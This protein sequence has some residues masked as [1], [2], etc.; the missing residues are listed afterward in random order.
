[1]LSCGVL[2]SCAA[3][4]ALPDRELDTEPAESGAD[5]PS[6][7]PPG[8]DDAGGDGGADAATDCG[9]DAALVACMG[10]CVD[11]STDHAHCGRCGRDCLEGSCEAGVYRL[12]ACNV[13]RS[14]SLPSCT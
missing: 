6:V 9:P 3:L 12:S 5:G 10:A 1:M 2:V 13:A 14:R 7:I 8:G 4:L 11:L